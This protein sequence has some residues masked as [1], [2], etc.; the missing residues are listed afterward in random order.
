VVRLSGCIEMLF[1]EEQDFLKRF[2]LLAASGVPA[3]EFWAFGDRDP[4][5]IAGAAT[6][7][8]LPVVAVTLEAEGALVDGPDAVPSLVAGLRA[9]A[10]KAAVVGCTRIIVL[11]GQE[12]Q[13]I[14]REEQHRNIVSGLGEMASV[15]GELG[16]T[17][18]LEPLNTLVDHKGYYLHTAAEGFEIV[19]EVGSP[20]V[21][22]LY[23]IYHMQV[24]QGNLIQ[25]IRENI[26]LIGHFHAADVPGR[27]EPG[28]GEIAWENV[29]QA[30]SDSG[31]QGFVGL[32]YKPTTDTPTSLA[33]ILSVVE[34][35]S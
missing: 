13:D 32:E 1:S 34:N 20:H 3:A 9:T 33:H 7:A 15:A 5:K 17:L 11:T 10:A 12:R 8:G 14:S 25:T 18:V 6:A 22:L 16:V 26:N 23:D 30:I 19:R 28:T 31:Y 21:Q 4:A 27:H 35:I 29:L 24:M 2:E